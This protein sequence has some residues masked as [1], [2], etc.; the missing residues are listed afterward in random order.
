MGFL[1]RLGNSPVVA[2][3]TRAICLG[4]SI[5]IGPI[6]EVNV[7]MAGATGQY[8]RDLPG[9]ALRG[10]WITAIVAL[11]AVTCILGKHDVGEVIFQVA[12]E[13]RWVKAIDRVSAT[14]HH[15]GQIHTLI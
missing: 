5:V 15:T 4:T 3:N 13:R 11:G 14:T 8:A 9:I 1:S 10:S 7:V 6:R 12:L 2:G